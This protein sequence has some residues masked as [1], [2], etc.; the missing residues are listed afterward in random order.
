MKE[1]I[2]RLKS[3]IVIAGILAQIVLIIA[4]FNVELSETF[5]AVATPIVTMLTLIGL[6]N[7]PTDK[8]NW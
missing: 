6:L 3:P 5:K 7:N 8:E 4:I 1:I 2:E